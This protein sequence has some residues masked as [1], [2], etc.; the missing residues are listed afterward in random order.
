MA[1]QIVVLPRQERKT[2]LQ[3]FTESF[4]PYLAM[5]MKA[6]IDRKARQP[7]LDIAKK[8]AEEDTLSGVAK[9]EL[10]ATSIPQQYL[11]PSSINTQG[12]TGTPETMAGLQNVNLTS[13][14]YQVNGTPDFMKRIM[15]ET[16]QA[17]ATRM[18]GAYATQQQN[19]NPYKAFIAA[20]NSVLL[21]I[22][23][24]VKNGQPLTEDERIFISLKSKEKDLD[25]QEQMMMAWLAKNMGIPVPTDNQPS[26][27]PKGKMRVRLKS[28]KQTG[29]INEDEFDPKIYEKF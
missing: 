18:Q 15:P 8:K 19:I 17:A 28:T 3:D 2:G 25:P 4:Q 12:L 23:E 29:T 10:P 21:P 7:E 27:S 24:K 5:A 22:Y 20:K 14:D 13:G 1:G 9:G 26:P 11:N 16:P 6:Y